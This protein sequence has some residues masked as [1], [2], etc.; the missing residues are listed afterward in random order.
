MKRS[1]IEGKLYTVIPFENYANT[2]QSYQN[3]N[4][5]IEY[6]LPNSNEI[7][8]LPVR[9][10]SDKRYGISK[11]GP[12]NFISVPDKN[13]EN[14]YEYTPENMV[15]F[16]NIQNVNQLIEQTELLQNL[17]YK[18]LT[19]PDN[20]TCPNITDNTSPAMRGLREAIISKNFDI[21]KYKDRFG[22]NFANDKRLLYNSDSI[23]LDRL[24]RIAENT[25]I[26]VSMIFKDKHTDIPNPMN[27]QIMVILT[28]NNEGE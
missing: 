10:S 2:L 4:V 16:T 21:D 22:E 5:A 23:T 14:Y 28:Q 1:Y 25:D 3:T 7:V 6:T 20:I 19:S 9:N 17:E 24:L 18:V 26:E 15:D 13:I 11:C 27:K 12:I 8:I